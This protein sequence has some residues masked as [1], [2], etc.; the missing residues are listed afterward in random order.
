MFPPATMFVTAPSM[1]PDPSCPRLSGSGTRRERN[2][3]REVARISVPRGRRRSHLPYRWPSSWPSLSIAA[4]TMHRINQRFPAMFCWYSWCGVPVSGHSA[5]A[6]AHAAGRVSIRN[7]LAPIRERLWNRIA[8]TVK[9]DSGEQ[10]IGVYIMEFHT[11][12]LRSSLIGCLS[13]PW[14]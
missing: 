11:A 2:A 8:P 5:F 13:S 4:S 12:H 3:R 9:P 10:I 6:M 14:T 7:G 1:L